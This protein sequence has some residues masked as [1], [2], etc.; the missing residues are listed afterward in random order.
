MPTPNP[1]NLTPGETLFHWRVIEVDPTGKRVT[2][3]CRCGQIRVIATA[4]LLAGT[5]TSCGCRPAPAGHGIARREAREQG[6][7]QR[8]YFDWLPER[9]R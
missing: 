7:R 2:A 6:Q 9:G 3:Q 5:R 1:S 4:D 8:Q